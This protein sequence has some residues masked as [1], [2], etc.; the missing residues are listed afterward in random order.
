MMENMAEKALLMGDSL[1]NTPGTNTGGSPEHLKRIKICRWTYLG[2]LRTFT[3]DHELTYIS[4]WTA[5]AS[6][7]LQQGPM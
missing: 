3:R 6:S 4:T 1:V 2:V 5:L 7:L